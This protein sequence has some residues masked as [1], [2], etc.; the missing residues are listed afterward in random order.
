MYWWQRPNLILLF[1][2]ARLENCGSDMYVLIL[3]ASVGH[4][5]QHTSG[6]DDSAD[7]RHAER[8][9]FRGRIGDVYEHRWCGQ[10]T[11]SQG[12]GS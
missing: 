9:E 3:H 1:F 8:S 2:T 5:V 6:H 11:Q 10:G 4:H 7:G 12:M